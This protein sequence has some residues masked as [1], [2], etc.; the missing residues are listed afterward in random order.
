MVRIEAVL[1][2]AEYFDLSNSGSPRFIGRAVA[3]LAADTDI[4]AKS[5]QVLVAAELGAAYGFTDVDG[6]RPASLRAG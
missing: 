6:R 4:M 2:A 3:T 1:K 5:G